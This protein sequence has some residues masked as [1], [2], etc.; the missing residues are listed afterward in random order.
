MEPVG[1]EHASE[2]LRLWP[3]DAMGDQKSP[4]LC[5]C[6]FTLQHEVEG[7]G[8]FLAAHAL[9]GVL[10]AAHLAQVLLEPLATAQSCAGHLRPSR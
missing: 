6:C 9:A 3:P 1:V 5:R 7:I 8:S 10:T 2:F 4:D